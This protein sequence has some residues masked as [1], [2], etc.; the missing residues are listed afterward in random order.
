MYPKDPN[1]LDM[2]PPEDAIKYKSRKLFNSPSDN[3]IPEIDRHISK[4]G[5]K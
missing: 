5:N 4:L 2:D 3:R 1:H